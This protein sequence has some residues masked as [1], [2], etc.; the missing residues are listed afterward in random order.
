MCIR[1]R[2]IYRNQLVQII[3]I[4]PSLIRREQAIEGCVKKYY[5]SDIYQI[6][7]TVRQKQYTVCSIWYAVSS[8]ILPFF[9]L[10]FQKKLFPIFKPFPLADYLIA[11]TTIETFS[12]FA[13]FVS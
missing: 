5:R 8:P 12:F 1:D 10:W 11:N 9:P 6:K 2:F 7:Q 13:V 4:L 3:I